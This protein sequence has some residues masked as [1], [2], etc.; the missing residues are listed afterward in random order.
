MKNKFLKIAI[1]A[2]VISVTFSC[3]D[4]IVDNEFNNKLSV[5]NSS[6]VQKSFIKPIGVSAKFFSTHA[7]VIGNEGNMWERRTFPGGTKKEKKILFLSKAKWNNLG[8]PKNDVDIIESIGI[9]TGNFTFP[10]YISNSNFSHVFVKG[11]DGNLWVYWEGKIRD[12]DNLG[13][14]INTSIDKTIGTLIV[15]NDKPYVFVKGFDN[16]LWCNYWTGANWNWRNQGKP[17]SNISV[18]ESMGAITVDGGDRPYVFVK[19]SDN[20]LWLNWWSGSKWIWSNQGKP[21]F[22]ISIVQSMGAITVDGGRP[23]VFVKG[24][25]GNLWSNWW[26]GSKWLWRNHSKPKSNISITESMGAITVDGGRPY[27]FVKGNDGNLWL[28]WWSGS[29]WF[30]SNHGKP[31]EGVSIV[32][33]YGAVTIEENKPHVYL[34]G[35]DGNLWV[36]WWSGS[37]WSWSSVP[38]N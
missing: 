8:K 15:D 31:S 25:D 3:E 12:W 14:P 23:Y 34:E 9:A 5:Q 36:N 13:E 33:S 26:S 4:V 29:K 32:K 22:N 38:L 19:G 24:N 7:Y 18:I 2:F 21:K 30:W 35:S 28:N 17:K 6:V 20:N 10:T 11:S 27:V 16:N 1:A 37:K